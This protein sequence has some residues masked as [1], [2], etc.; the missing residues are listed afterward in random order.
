M[1]SEMENK[2]PSD[3]EGESQYDRTLR[4]GRENPP[5]GEDPE[6]IEV[7]YLEKGSIWFLFVRFRKEIDENGNLYWK[8][9][10]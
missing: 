3:H 7:P 6:W 5:K 8:E 9:V 10:K 1:K 4:W 2:L